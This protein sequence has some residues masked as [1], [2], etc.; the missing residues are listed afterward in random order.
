MS[1]AE[2]ARTILAGGNLGQRALEEAAVWAT[3]AVAEALESLGGTPTPAESP[4]AAY[5]REEADWQQAGA[6]L[7][8]EAYTVSGAPTPF[9]GLHKVIAH[10]YRSGHRAGRR[11]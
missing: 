7:L 8:R 10:A 1:A 11:G 4:E 3:L 9:R 5:E 6:A 2:A